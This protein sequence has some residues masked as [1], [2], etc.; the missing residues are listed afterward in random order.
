[1]KYIYLIA[2]F[3]MGLS[4]PLQAQNEPSQNAF[5][6]LQSSLNE[7]MEDAA[8]TY[9]SLKQMYDEYIRLGMLMSSDIRMRMNA[10]YEKEEI[11][12]GPLG[13]GSSEHT[14]SVYAEFDWQNMAESMRVKSSESESWVEINALWGAQSKQSAKDFT[15]YI[16][17]QN[18]W[19]VP[20]ESKEIQELD[21]NAPNYLRVNPM[22]GMQNMAK[23]LEVGLQAAIDAKVAEMLDQLAV[24]AIMETNTPGNGWLKDFIPEQAIAAYTDPNPDK[25]FAEEQLKTVLEEL[26]KLQFDQI[27]M[28]PALI[29]FAFIISPT[30]ARSQF[31]VQE[32]PVTWR[33]QDNCIKM[34]VLSGSGAGSMVVFDRYGRLIHLRDN[35]GDTADYWYD[36]DV[37]VNI[38]PAVSINM[39]QYLQNISNK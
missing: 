12:Y 35:D 24:L 21:E 14:G 23:I 5:D 31:N 17:A 22:G 38:P 26:A 37:T 6:G 36:K 18:Y 2:I 25:S 29:H 19:Y 27:S 28:F 13:A 3:L 7:L 1:M 20:F 8:E 9:E 4:V 33:G 30:L 15:M 32:V 16:D 10:K 39:D 34:S 11:W